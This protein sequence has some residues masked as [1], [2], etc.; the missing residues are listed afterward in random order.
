MGTVRQLVGA[1]RPQLARTEFEFASRRAVG[2]RHLWSGGVHMAG[3]LHGE[4]AQMAWTKGSRHAEAR[5][6]P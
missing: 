1:T 4:M 3:S 2:I 5:I 6:R